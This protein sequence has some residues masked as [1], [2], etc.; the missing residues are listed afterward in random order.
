MAARYRIWRRSDTSYYA[1][2]EEPVVPSDNL[3]F[4]PS[5][6]SKKKRRQLSKNSAVGKNKHLCEWGRISFF[7]F[8]FFFPRWLFSFSRHVA[9]TDALGW[10]TRSGFLLPFF[11]VMRARDRRRRVVFTCNS[12]NNQVSAQQRFL[13]IIFTVYTN[14]ERRAVYC[15]TPRFA[16]SSSSCQSR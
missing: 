6:I 9:Q 12:H 14:L 10:N 2:Q 1:W 7:F 8:F 4:S 3:S 15:L 11:S 13:F 5:V 16:H